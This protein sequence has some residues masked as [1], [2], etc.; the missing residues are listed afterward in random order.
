[1]RLYG[2][3]TNVTASAVIRVAETYNQVVSYGS[4]TAS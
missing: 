3:T 1:M 4:V 2:A